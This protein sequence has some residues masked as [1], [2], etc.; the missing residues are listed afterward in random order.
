MVKGMYFQPAFWFTSLE[1]PF[2]CVLQLS[3]FTLP[4]LIYT[5]FQL[6]F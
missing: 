3:T 1:R 4:E 5:K 6:Y 2:S